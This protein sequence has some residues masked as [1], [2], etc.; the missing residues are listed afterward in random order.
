MLPHVRHFWSRT[1]AAGRSL[2]VDVGILAPQWKSAA[3]SPP[4]GLGPPPSLGGSVGGGN[5]I[6]D[7]AAEGEEEEKRE[8]FVCDLEVDGVVRGA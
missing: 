7:V 6:G 3:I 2:W 8:S 1:K 5:D 4:P